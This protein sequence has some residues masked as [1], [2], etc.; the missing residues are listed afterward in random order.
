MKYWCSC[1]RWSVFHRPL[2]VWP[3]YVS[4]LLLFCSSK[5]LS[6]G[7][8][9]SDSL[10]DWLISGV[11]YQLGN[12]AKKKQPTL[13]EIPDKMGMLTVNSAGSNRWW[14]F[15]LLLQPFSDFVFLSAVDGLD[16][17]SIANSDGPTAGSQTP[18][19]K[20]KGKLS[21]IGKIFKPW[22]WRKKKTSD[23]FRE[24]SAGTNTITWLEE[25]IKC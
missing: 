8:V 16:K 12:G 14:C 21:T 15:K 13:C 11:F 24:T 6:K 25:K 20:R 1:C 22:K 5:W 10:I 17:A 19:F 18:P 4:L 2:L 9:I 23:K 3:Y 7:T